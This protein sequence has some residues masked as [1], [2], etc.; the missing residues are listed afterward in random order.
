LLEKK[1]KSVLL[2]SDKEELNFTPGE[3]TRKGKD[4]TVYAI[5]EGTVFFFPPSKKNA[6]MIFKKN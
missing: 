2:S 4:D 5:K 1:P 6:S 3:N